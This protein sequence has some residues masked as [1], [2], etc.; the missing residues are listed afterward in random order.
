M[1]FKAGDRVRYTGKQ[2]GMDRYMLGLLG[3]V[4]RE[5]P[6]E[7][8]YVD[9]DRDQIWDRKPTHGVF[10]GNVELLDPPDLILAK[11][12]TSVAGGDIFALTFPDGTL[13]VMEA[14]WS[15]EKYHL[16]INGKEVL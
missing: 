14:W 5:A 7:T 16:V 9:W 13:L 15:E 3:T 4:E 10:R 11:I 2:N 12:G 1:T 6:E 8:V